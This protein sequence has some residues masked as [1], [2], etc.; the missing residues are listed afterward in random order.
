[1][2]HRLCLL[3]A[4]FVVFAPLSALDSMILNGTKVKT[5]TYLE[6]V[7]ILT[8]SSQCT[9]TIVG[10]STI[11]TAAHCAATG[12]TSHFDYKGRSYKAKITRIDGYPAKDLDVAVGV[13]SDKIVDAVPMT[14]GGAATKGLAVSMLGYGCTEIPDDQKDPIPGTPDEGDD[15][16]GW[17]WPWPWTST[18]GTTDELMRG[19]TSVSGFDNY[20]MVL[21]KIGGGAVCFGDSGGPSI[22]ETKGSTLIL[23]IN[24]K[25][26]IKDVSL[27]FRL[28]IAESQA[29]L[30]KFAKDQGVDICGINK[31][32]TK[33][34]P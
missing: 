20:D 14:I 1:M 21:T 24:S 4:A 30:K 2:K 17:P 8:G 33:T 31:T 12:E 16:G 28:D 26:N 11:I 25:G 10:P 19:E 5:G 29:F 27:G 34:T 15:D 22:V 6:V 3:S 32:C 18:A 7:K 9:A 13:T 23:G